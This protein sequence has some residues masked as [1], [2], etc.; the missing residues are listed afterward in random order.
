MSLGL[1]FGEDDMREVKRPKKIQI[2]DMSG[3]LAEKVPIVK[4]LCGG[5]HTVALANTGA[6][7]S[8]GCNDEGALGR[9]GCEDK[10][11][12]VSLPIRATDISCGDSH[13]VFYSTEENKAYFTGLYRVSAKIH[14]NVLL[15]V[16]LNDRAHL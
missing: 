15:C 1:E 4:L 5:M 8:W 6:V 3:E 13:S 11:M 14:L 10:P 7:Y 9:P 12:L 2:F 16:E